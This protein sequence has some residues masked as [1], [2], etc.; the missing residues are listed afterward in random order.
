MN[1]KKTA[2]LERVK[3][4]KIAMIEWTVL[5]LIFAP[6][7]HIKAQE[8]LATKLF[9]N[10]YHEMHHVNGMLPFDLVV[11]AAKGAENLGISGI[12]I[13]Q[14]LSAYRLGAMEALIYSKRTESLIGSELED[15]CKQTSDSSWQADSCGYIAGVRIIESKAVPVSMESFGYVK[16]TIRGQY[17]FKKNILTSVGPDTYVVLAIWADDS[18]DP[19][20]INSHDTHYFDGYLSTESFFADRRDIKSREFYIVGFK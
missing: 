11:D 19:T 7:S 2:V 1:P 15:G 10:A 6:L 13:R 17:S 3:S 20:E 4:H 16:K 8:D 5:L 18:S 14:Y 9:G 12:Q